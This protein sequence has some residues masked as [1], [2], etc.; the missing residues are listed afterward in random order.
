MSG[1]RNVEPLNHYI[2]IVEIGTRFHSSPD[3]TITYMP[4]SECKV[5]QNRGRILSTKTTIKVE[6]QNGKTFKIVRHPNG[7][8][9]A[10]TF[11]TWVNR[12]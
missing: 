5:R 11:F 6:S 3:V 7:E 4:R 10:K 9:K 12:V 8:Y 1:N 2:E